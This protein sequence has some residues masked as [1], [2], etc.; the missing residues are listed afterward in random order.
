MTS[1]SCSIC[2]DTLENPVS[3][4]CGHNF[5]G[6]C[7]HVFVEYHKN[8]VLPCPYCS[9]P[10]IATHLHTNVILAELINP[11][12]KANATTDW[13]L[14]EPKPKTKNCDSGSWID[15]AAQ[16]V[17]FSVGFFVLGWADSKGPPLSYNKH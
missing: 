8:H 15:I 7:I 16:I 2:L 9:Q 3:L 11:E 5:C 6:E 17:I 14:T 13:G 12:G 4:G 10:F 1:H